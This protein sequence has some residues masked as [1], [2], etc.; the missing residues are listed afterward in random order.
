MRGRPMVLVL[1]VACATSQDI[2]VDGSAAV[3]EAPASGGTDLPEGSVEIAEDE[4]VLGDD[5]AEPVAER[6][7]WRGLECL[8]E[9]PTR[10]DASNPC[11]PGLPDCD[12]VVFEASCR[13]FTDPEN[14]PQ[15]CIAK[16]QEGVWT[17]CS[18]AWASRLGVADAARILHQ[19]LLMWSALSRVYDH[20]PWTPSGYAPLPDNCQDAERALS[21]ASAEVT[22]SGLFVRFGVEHQ[23]CAH[24]LLEGVW[25][26]GFGAGSIRVPVRST[27]VDALEA[28]GWTVTVEADGAWATSSPFS[29]TRVLSGRIADLGRP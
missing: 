6:T 19:P 27:C 11:D 25:G 3:S 12:L 20:E 13:L 15:V 2:G 22:G 9:G 5:T 10:W 1:T 8:A 21:H 18:E 17:E 26:G 4:V 16:D 29:M 7:S 24:P 14:P 28:D 23:A